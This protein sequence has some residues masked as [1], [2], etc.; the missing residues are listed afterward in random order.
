MPAAF[1]S[2]ALVLAIFPVVGS[3]GQAS[4]SSPTR[5]AIGATRVLVR[6]EA[7]TST[8]AQNA[9][10]ARAGARR[11]GEIEQLG[12]A[13]VTVPARTEK[14]AVRRLG[15]S[16]VVAY[17]ERDGL[18]RA[19][20]VSAHDPYLNSTSWQLEKLNLPDA[21]SL[22]TGSASIV[23]AVLDSGVDRR[24]EDLGA[25]VPGHDFIGKDTNTSD[26][27][28]HGTAVAGTIAAEGGN[29]K[30]IAGVCWKCKIMP[31]KVL[32]ADN[33]GSWS[34]VAAGVIWAT[35]HG[36]RVINMSLGLPSGSRSIAAAVSYAIKHNVIVVA[37]SGN[38]NSTKPDYPAAYAGVLS[39]GAV[40]EAGTR[41]STSN[42]TVRYGKWGSNY[43]SWVEV[44][45]PG[46]A[47]STS[48][49]DNYTYFCGTSAA[50]PFAAGLA[51]LA[52]SYVPGA[53]AAQVVS[54]IESTAHQTEDKN[55]AHG[56]IDAVATLKM[57]ASR[58][59]ASTATS[60]ATGAKISARLTKK[61]FA[62]SQAPKVKLVY[63]F[64]SAGTDFGYRLER[65]NGAGW[66]TV[67][68]VK[69]QGDFRGAHALT[70]KQLFGRKAIASGK[71]RLLLRSGA[72]RARV[73]FVAR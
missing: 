5:A 23:V 18:A 52:L 46:C 50:A 7:H 27:N 57:L 60:V 15:A 67:R 22:S 9:A 34:D 43:G 54:A 20:R 61:T 29:G 11:L 24:H 58:S 32:G 55:S 6:F 14:A 66:K 53:S 73:A 39:V 62:R 13:V 28:G 56:L 30:G 3:V 47:N 35:K 49:G 25:F 48:P 12:I 26:S 40:D 59:S 72:S 65:R 10:L 37:S 68:S 17:V 70:I 38:E 41:Y 4:A 69:Q 21:W 33:S 45:A 1:R 42:H 64:S 16:P 2:L 51:G 63:R 8:V 19:N 31:V 36:A 44:D 71:Y